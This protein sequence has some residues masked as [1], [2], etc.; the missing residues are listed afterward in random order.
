M[1]HHNPLKSPSYL[2]DIQDYSCCP[3]ETTILY[4]LN[5]YQIDY[6]FYDLHLLNF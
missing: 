5:D 2:D 1:L 6:R 4:F 3:Y